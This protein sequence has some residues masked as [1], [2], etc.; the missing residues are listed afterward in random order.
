VTPL[1]PPRPPRE[2]RARAVYRILA[3]LFALC[4]AAQVLLA[5]LSVFLDASWWHAHRVFGTIF[6]IVL[7]LALVAATWPARMPGR[8]RRLAG[9]AFGLSMLQGVTAAIGGVAGALHPVG[10]LA[11]FWVA[12]AMARP[13][14]AGGAEAAPVAEGGWSRLAAGR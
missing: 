9:A 10:A 3:V 4:V 12:L 6:G 7:P 8:P 13:A 11:L 1:P 5:G 2:R 14:R